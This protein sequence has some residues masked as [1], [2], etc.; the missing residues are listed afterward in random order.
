[1]NTRQF[2]SG[3]EA[4]SLGIKLARPEVIAAYPITPQTIVV[5]K[6][7]DYVANG[8]LDCNYIHVE[9]EHS[10]LA[11][12]LGSSAMGVRSFTATSSQGLLYMS[13]ILSYSSGAR[14]PIVMLNANR[15]I[16]I[17]WSIYGDHR[18]SLSVLDSGWIQLYV[19]NAQEALDV[20]IQ[21]FKLAEDPSVLNPVMVNLDGF[22]LTHT[23]EVVEVPSQED[24]DKFLP[25]LQTENKLD[26]NNPRSMCISVG[27]EWNTEFQVQHHLAL[28]NAKKKLAEI[29]AEYGAAFGR[30]YGGMVEEIEC[31]DAD[32]VM[33]MMGSSI[34]TA[35]DVIKK[36]RG[37]GKKVGILKIRSLRPF[38]V[39]EVQAVG[40]H[41]KAMGVIDRDISFG[42]EGAVYSDVNSALMRL[43][44]PPKTLNFIAGLGG[45]NFTKEEIEKAFDSLFAAANGEGLEERV[46]FLD[47][48][49][50]K[51]GC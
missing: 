8:E 28:M 49:C 10:A 34:G 48:R 18:D 17:P 12:V 46:K 19:E 16:A 22:M 29:D 33:V 24:V 37:E 20:M 2:V 26:I 4:A 41:V 15:S 9:S 44:N 42:Y 36:M 14:R 7:S 43:D 21:A 32:V 35:R 13:E 50:D 31:A 51:H 47:L 3:D 1:M 45:R 11:A 39:E 23:Y 5:E 25:S 38:P 30:S 27:P 40:K 6:L